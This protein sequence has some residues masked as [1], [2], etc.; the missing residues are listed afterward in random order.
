MADLI[1]ITRQ[2]KDTEAASRDE[3]SRSEVNKRAQEE[4]EAVR[5]SFPRPRLSVHHPW[6]H[7]VD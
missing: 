5:K 3:C 7:K 6:T 2:H 1:V 4:Q